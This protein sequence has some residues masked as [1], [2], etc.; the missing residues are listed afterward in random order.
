MVCKTQKAINCISTI[1]LWDACNWASLLVLAA[2]NY[3]SQIKCSL[4]LMQFQGLR[5]NQLWPAIGAIMYT[6]AS[7]NIQLLLFVI[8]I[9][10]AKLPGG[11]YTHISLSQVV[12]FYTVQ[13]K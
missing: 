3:I 13:F 5:N 1:M 11:S 12:E 10:H 8:L 7:L 9:I 6:S 2:I 4:A